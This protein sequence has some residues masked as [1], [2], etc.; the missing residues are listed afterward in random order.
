MPKTMT[1]R[2]PARSER[3]LL[4]VVSTAPSK[5]R[6]TVTTLGDEAIV[7]IDSGSGICS[8]KTHLVEAKR[9]R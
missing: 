9:G 1:E 4:G 7:F 2:A 5:A 3:D 8:R 6:F